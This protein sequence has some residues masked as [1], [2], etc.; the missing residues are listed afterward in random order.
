MC[1]GVLPTCMSVHHAHAEPE[2]ARKGWG[3]DPPG[4]GVADSCRPLCGCLELNPFLEEL[5]VLLT[6]EPFL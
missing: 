4:S 1:I 3:S 6:A 5:P 2:D